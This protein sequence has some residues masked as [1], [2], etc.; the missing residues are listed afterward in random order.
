MKEVLIQLIPKDWHTNID[1][2]KC[3]IYWLNKPHCSESKPIT[4]FNGTVQYK[5]THS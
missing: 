3:K 4:L 5:C 2:I 1:N